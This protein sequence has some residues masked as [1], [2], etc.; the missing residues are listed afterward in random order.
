MPFV[1]PLTYF[2]LLPHNSAFL[3]S[4]SPV[5]YDGPTS[6]G[7]A[8]TLPYTPLPSAEDEDGEE[9]G[10]LPPGPRK[11]VSLS[12]SDK[13]RLVKPLLLKYMLPLCE[14]PYPTMDYISY[15]LVY[16]LRVSC[17]LLLMKVYSLTHILYHDSSSI[18]SIKYERKLTFCACGC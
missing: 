18:L 5:G 15:Q 1:I 16:S 3:Y 6:P 4:Q 2:Y 13:W 7:G 12:P 14:L 8:S 10:S 17:E 11:G 9:E